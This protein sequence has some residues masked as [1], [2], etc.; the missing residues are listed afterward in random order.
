MHRPD[1]Q[2]YLIICLSSKIRMDRK[3]HRPSSTLHSMQPR[4]QSRVRAGSFYPTLGR[5]HL[6]LLHFLPQIVS[7][8]VSLAS[9]SAFRRWLGACVCG[10][11]NASRNLKVFIFMVRVWKICIGDGHH[12]G[13]RVVNPKDS[14]EYIFIYFAI[15]VN[16]LQ[17]GC[18]SSY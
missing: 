1:T 3:C 12:G 4:K 7:A 5:F 16:I 14:G 10:L 13:T 9:P 18:L 6:I 11:I 15:S 8:F 2:Y 17:C